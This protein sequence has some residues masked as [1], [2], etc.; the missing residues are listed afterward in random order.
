MRCKTLAGGPDTLGL[1]RQLH[2]ALPGGP[3]RGRPLES[4]SGWLHWLPRTAARAHVSHKTIS[5]AHVSHK[6]I[7]RRVDAIAGNI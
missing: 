6:T 7:K 3:G 2:H 5:R 4:A 1:G